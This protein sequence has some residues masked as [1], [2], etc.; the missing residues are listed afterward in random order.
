LIIYYS[1][2]DVWNAVTTEL[3]KKSKQ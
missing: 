2:M 1:G 3:Q